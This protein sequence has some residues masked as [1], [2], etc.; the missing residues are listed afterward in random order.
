VFIN[1]HSC[2]S[3]CV[4]NFSFFKC[5][6]VPIDLCAMSTISIIIVIIMIIN[7]SNSSTQGGVYVAVMVL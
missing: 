5:I 3:V 6:H 4:F 7:N 2:Y 1:V